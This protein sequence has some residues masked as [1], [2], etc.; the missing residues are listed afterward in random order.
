MRPA[1]I[2]EVD[3]A[4]ADGRWAAAYAPQREAVVPHDL[5]AAVAERPRAA[6]AFDA[7]G[8]SEQY[9]LILDVVTARSPTTRAARIRTAIAALEGR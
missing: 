6:A 1:G 2:A 3:A 9:A 5:A 4:K 8:K 7:L